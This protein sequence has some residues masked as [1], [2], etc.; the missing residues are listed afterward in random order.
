MTTTTMPEPIDLGALCDAHANAGG[1][2]CRD[3]DDDGC[4][5]ACGVSMTARCLDCG[6]VGYCRPTCTWV[7]EMGHLV[8]RESR[9]EDYDPEQHGKAV[10]A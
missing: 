4:C 5:D 3:P 8:D 6:G 1:D 10:T 2:L 7:V 9:L